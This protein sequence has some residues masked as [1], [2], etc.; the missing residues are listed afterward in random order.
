METTLVALLALFVLAIAGA[1]AWIT[2]RLLAVEQENIELRRIIFTT[3][4]AN[5]DN[6]GCGGVAILA[7]LGLGLLLWLML[8]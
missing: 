7:L 8:G 3:S 1:F 4:F 5:A 6:S 2:T